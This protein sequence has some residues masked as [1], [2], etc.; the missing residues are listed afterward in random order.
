MSFLQEIFSSFGSDPRTQERLKLSK[1]HKWKFKAKMK[2][3]KKDEN[4][5]SFS[6]FNSKGK[7]RLKGILQFDSGLVD[8]VFRTYDLVSASG[9]SN[10]T[11][12]VFEFRNEKLSVSKFAIV[13]KKKFKPLKK[14]FTSSDHFFATSPEFDELYDIQTENNSKIVQD[15]NEDFLDLIGDK[16]GW[17]VEGNGQII[18]YYQRNQVFEKETFEKN[19][20]QFVHIS[21]RLIN[22]SSVAGGPYPR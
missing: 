21:E 22:G 16:P 13:P 19:L 11:T 20:V 2:V 1:K 18:I 3:N 17:I 5:K 8:G 6:L 12:T 9:F 15:L 7:K 4:F 14:I 10:K